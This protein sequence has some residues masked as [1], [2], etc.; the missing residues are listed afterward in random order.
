MEHYHIKYIS[1]LSFSIRLKRKSFSWNSSLCWLAHME[2]FKRGRWIKISIS[3]LHTL[4]RSLLLTWCYSVNVPLIPCARGTRWFPE[5]S[6]VGY[7]VRKGDLARRG[8]TNHVSK[9]DTR[10]I[11][12]E[13][14]LT[15][16]VSLLKLG[17][18]AL[19]LSLACLQVMAIVIYILIYLV[20]DFSI[21]WS[22]PLKTRARMH[23]TPLCC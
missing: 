20:K 9:S 14:A 13:P 23:G 11:I 3:A 1:F 18:V 4:F 2:T 5:H 17:H 16:V 6:D 21:T 15:K 19:R 10:L 12:K 22:D 7:N 8:A